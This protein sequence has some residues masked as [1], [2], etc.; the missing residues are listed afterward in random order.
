MAI[1]CPNKGSKE[2]QDLVEKL[3]S[4]ELAYAEWN[5][6][7]YEESDEDP[8]IN[9][10]NEPDSAELAKKFE[11]KYKKQYVY[12]TRRLARLKQDLKSKP[13]Q[14]EAA[15]K[16]Q[17]EIDEIST[18]LEEAKTSHSKES[19]LELGTKLLDNIE[20]YLTGLKSGK[21]KLKI[22]DIN[23]TRE[24]LDI[25]DDFRGLSDRSKDLYDQ[26]SP[27]I[28][29][30]TLEEINKYSTEDFEITR[31]KLE[32][33]N[34]DINRVR[35]GVGALSDLADYLG[36][37]VGSIIKAAQNRISTKNKEITKEIQKE[38]DDLKEYSSKNEISGN[39]MYDPF[40]Q[41]LNGTT[42]L[43]REFTSEYYEKRNKAFRNLDSTDI[44]LQKEARTWLKENT[45]YDENNKFVPS[46]PEFF[47]ENYKKIQETPELKKF[48]DFHQK[49]TAEAKLKLPVAIGDNFI[50]NIKSSVTTDIL[51]GDKKLLAGL[52][53]GLNNIISV[54]SFTEGQFVGDEDL[55]A[56][57]VP[58]KYV[59]K[60]SADEK[61]RDLGE[62]LLKFAA[63]ANSYE[64]MSEVLPQVRLLQEEIKK[65]EYVKSSDPK[66]KVLG[67]NSNIYKMVD[68]YIKIQVK[69]ESKLEEGKL[70]LK[71]TYD[72]DGNVT[73]EKYVLAS[74]IVDFGL[75]YN[76]LLR[77]GLNPINAVTNWLVGDIGN[78]IEGFGAR[79]YTL[80][81][82]N[83]ATNLFFKQNFNEKS[84]MNHLLEELN[85]LQELEDYENVDKVRIKGKFSGEGAKNIMYKPQQI[86]E[87]FLQT[88]TMLAIM[89]KD[90]LINSKGELTD[91]YK[92]LTAADK[93]K[94][95]D[96]IQRVNQSIHGRYSSRDAATLQQNVLFRAV[97]QFRKWIPAAIESR[98]GGYQYD[99]RLG[100]DIEGR[101]STAYRLL[102]KD[103]KNTIE[104]LKTG[105]LTEL[106]VYNMRKNLIE[107]VIMLGTILLYAGL[108]GGDDDKK[109]RANPFV[110]F[111]LGQ[112]DRVSGDLLFFLS[113]SEYNKMAQNAV[114]LSKT[115]T[116]LLKVGSYVPYIFYDAG[117]EEVYQSGPRKG[118]SK[119]TSRIGSLIPGWKPLGDAARIWNGVE[120]TE[121]K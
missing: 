120:F 104:K 84:V 121:F 42:V 6:S 91:E 21:I 82:L 69:G 119:F 19:Y 116:D 90:G 46:K 81:D 25:F 112:L 52:K 27:Y 3:G 12:F 62:N 37:T 83:T 68:D 61:S 98:F 53:E 117:K 2:F 35:K 102:I 107:A 58:I 60:I 109:R 77:I 1:K 118:E 113:P 80:R 108:K 89:L 31:E 11:S 64:E 94:L 36:R 99:N 67:E 10:I 33:Q 100:A 71:K 79:F 9:T 16:L 4:E 54:K 57:V 115:I 97:S 30:L 20:S 65:K 87:K 39:K 5:N 38:V 110:K 45:K 23:Y 50:A 95:S 15:I 32:E 41:T 85:P 66:K 34:K 18:K 106:E 96:K 76:S 101:Y 78:I 93:A 22:K 72:E 59:A 48:Y 56:D 114:P 70:V 49:I 29:K 111:S 86:G 17:Q 75:K 13:D 43:T 103:L 47:N 7:N 88:R 55:V 74:E 26:L 51:N 63:F 24:V 44:A 105:N 92:S 14:S 8:S 73:G 40:I 28:D